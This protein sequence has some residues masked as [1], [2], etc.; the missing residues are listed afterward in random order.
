MTAA[1][2]VTVLVDD[3][4]AL[5]QEL[6]DERQQAAEVAGVMAAVAGQ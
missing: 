3:A 6:V 5:V 2:A 1:E 4:V